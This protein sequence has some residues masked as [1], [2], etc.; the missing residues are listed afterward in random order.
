MGLI[1]NLSTCSFEEFKGIISGSRK[2]T[3]LSSTYNFGKYIY[4]VQIR[5]S[6]S[7]ARLAYSVFKALQRCTQCL[8][9]GSSPQSVPSG[10]QCFLTSPTEQT[11]VGTLDAALGHPPASSPLTFWLWILDTRSHKVWEFCSSRYFLT[12]YNTYPTSIFPCSH[13][14]LT[15][16]YS[17]VSSDTDL[18]THV[19]TTAQI[20]Q[21][22][23]KR[24]RHGGVWG[25][26]W[27]EK[28][29][30][31]FAILT[32]FLAQ[33]HYLSETHFPRYKM[34]IINTTIN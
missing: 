16:T 25:C 10:V 7:P 17:T 8:L 15:M 32:S 34:Y 11:A 9:I 13:I 3:N 22:P 23:W 20:I 21:H 19:T 30:A 12:G 6:Y 14:I 4:R 2:W 18:N 28:R 1:F 31:I 27:Q 24:T 5:S 33:Y 26:G 29:S